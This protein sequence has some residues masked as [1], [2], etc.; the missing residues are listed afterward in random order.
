MTTYRS[1]GD[2]QPMIMVGG[3]LQGEMKS[4]KNHMLLHRTIL[5]EGAS[6]FEKEP[7]K[8]VPMFSSMYTQEKVFKDRKYDYKKT[9]YWIRVWK[10]ESIPD[11]A[12][13]EMLYLMYKEGLIPSGSYVEQFVE[14]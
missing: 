5:D 6:S 9:V 12:L 10:H 3:P 1:L 11:T 4:G 8:V 13:E 2:D 7:E 14:L